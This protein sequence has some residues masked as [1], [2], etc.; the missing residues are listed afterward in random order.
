MKQMTLAKMVYDVLRILEI[1][2]VDDKGKVRY[3]QFSDGQVMHLSEDDQLLFLTIR[4]GFR[5]L[6]KKLKWNLDR[7]MSEQDMMKVYHLFLANL[8]NSRLR[9][10][11]DLESLQDMRHNA[12]MHLVEAM[13]TQDEYKR[14]IEAQGDPKRFTLRP[15]R[16]VFNTKKKDPRKRPVRRT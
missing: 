14:L 15:L 9:Y 8:Q 13:G 2:E 11:V 1:G 10:P 16:P 7:Q 3:L 12:H 5:Y 6:T 4:R